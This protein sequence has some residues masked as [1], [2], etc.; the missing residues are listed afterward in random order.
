MEEAVLEVI[1]P[2]RGRQVG[3]DPAPEAR[4]GAREMKQKVS[5]KIG[6]DHTAIF[7]QV[8]LPA[9]LGK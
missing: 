5:G 7:D 2:G 6:A 8:A 4:A 3:E 1:Q 9:S